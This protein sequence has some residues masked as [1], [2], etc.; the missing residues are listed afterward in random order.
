VDKSTFLVKIG[1]HYLMPT[2]S[3]RFKKVFI[4][5]YSNSRVPKSLLFIEWVLPLHGMKLVPS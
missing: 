2:Y 1:I 5:P 4:A 3:N